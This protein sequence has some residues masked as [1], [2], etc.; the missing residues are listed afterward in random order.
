MKAGITLNFQL[1]PNICTT[2]PATGSM[3]KYTSMM[4]LSPIQRFSNKAKRWSGWVHIG[5]HLQMGPDFKF[6]GI[7]QIMILFV[8]STIRILAVLPAISSLMPFTS[9]TGIVE[10]VFHN[11]CS[12]TLQIIADSGHCQYQPVHFNPAYLASSRQCL[13]G[14]RWC[15]FRR[16][17][18]IQH[19]QC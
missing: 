10:M 16:C 14:F 15:C 17:Q 9:I 18:Y 13:L 11:F 12:G 3:P 19:R 4:P 8:W 6:M 5:V 7:S 1:I 2:P